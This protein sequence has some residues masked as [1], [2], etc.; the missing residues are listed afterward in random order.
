MDDYMEK[1]LTN[2]KPEVA[3]KVKAGVKRLSKKT[4]INIIQAEFEFDPREMVKRYPGPTLIIQTSSE[5]KQPN[6]L[7]NQVPGVPSK[8]IHRTSHWPQLDSPEEFNQI[9]DDFLS[10]VKQE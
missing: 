10:Q 6:A 4:S 9:L 2:A 8:T 5:Q 3:T 1:L 7:C